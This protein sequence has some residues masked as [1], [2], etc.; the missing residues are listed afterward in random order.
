LLVGV[1]V[2]CSS[3]V[4]GSCCFFTPAA[5]WTSCSMA[6]RAVQVSKSFGVPLLHKASRTL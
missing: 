4:M 3:I 2:L 5:S 1:S 6:R